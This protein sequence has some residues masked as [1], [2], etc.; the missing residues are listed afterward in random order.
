[1]PP[2]RGRSLALSP[3]RRLVG[4]LLHFARRL[5][6]VPVQRAMTL[7]PVVA[8]RARLAERPSWTVVFARAFA[9][10]AAE[11]PELRR[12]Y[13]GF[14]RPHLYEHPDSVAAVALEREVAGEPAVLVGQLLDPAGQGL[15]ALDGRLRHFRT[16]PVE[17]LGRF[18]LALRVSRMPRPLRRFLWWAVLNLSGPQRALRMG[19]FG[20]TAYSALGA[21]SLHP[22]S[23]LTTTLTYGVIAPDGGVTVRVSYDHRVLDGATVARALARM[24]EVLCGPIVREL[25]TLAGPAA[26]GTAAA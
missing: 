8:A 23:P 24:E 22:I 16:K 18:R 13:L 1:M 14:P 20:V 9:L 25:E 6:T 11:V 2:S 19:T 21:E 3:A 17:E 5:P 7:A 12:A 4:D 15:A 10:V 26:I